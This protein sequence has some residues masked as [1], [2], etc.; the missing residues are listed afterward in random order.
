[1]SDG[2]TST[3]IQLMDGFNRVYTSVRHPF[4][5]RYLLS[6]GGDADADGLTDEDEIAYGTDPN[7]PDTDDDGLSDGDELLNYGTNPLQADS[8]NDQLSDGAEIAGGTNPLLA[9]TDN[10]GLGDGVELLLGSNPNDN[11]DTASRLAQGTLLAQSLARLLVVDPSSGAWA[12][13]A[14]LGSPGFSLAYDQLGTLYAIR[15]GELVILE[16]FTGTVLQT[17]GVVETAASDPVTIGQLSYSSTDSL[18]YGVEYAA[19]LPTGQLVSIDPSSAEATRLGGGHSD[20]IGAVIVDDSGTLLAVMRGSGSDELVELSTADGSVAA[21]R[22][23][24]GVADVWGLAFASDGTL[25]AMAPQLT[26]E[27]HLLSID[28]T[29]GVASPAATLS[30]INAFDITVRTLAPI[31]LVV[32]RAGSISNVSAT[33]SCTNSSW[34]WDP[35]LIC[36]V[37]ANPGPITIGA[38]PN[39]SFGFTSTYWQGCSSSAGNSCDLSLSGSGATIY[40]CFNDG[41]SSAQGTCAGYWP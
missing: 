27:S 31:T 17:L 23:G 15:S 39:Q 9:D 2:S 41:S 12:E 25:L 28:I 40:A 38:T 36:N 35:P 20:P 32:R 24:L 5:F 10:D 34:E 1:M 4:E 14:N 8:D 26:G 21:T 19:G 37:S 3:E 7:D 18:L 30:N 22:G 13:L 16:A 33:F 29:T 11:A 6:L